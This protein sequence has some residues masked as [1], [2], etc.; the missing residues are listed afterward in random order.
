[1]K[2]GY[3]IVVILLCFASMPITAQTKKGM[4]YTLKYENQD[5]SYEILLNDVPVA[6][7]FGLSSGFSLKKELNQYILKS[8]KQEI[9]IRIYPQKKTETSFEATVSKTAK[10][11][12]SIKKNTEPLSLLDIANARDKGIQT[13]WDVVSFETPKIESDG[14]FYEF[15]TS[16]NVNDKDITWK[17]KGWI[18]SKDL[19]NETDLRKQVDAFYEN[20]KNIL[21]SKKQ[22]EYLKL[23]KTS[24][25]EEALSKPWFGVNFEKDLSNEILKY[26]NDERNFIYPCENAELKFYAN[27][28]IVTLIC[29][30]ITIFGYSPLISKTA[31]N[32]MPK[33]HTIYLHKPKNSDELEIIR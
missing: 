12:I 32:A 15:K 29:K 28:K 7:N 3:L 30:D 8:G 19:R 22:E 2:K 10:V 4:L 27:G 11:K 31:K 9:T 23:L 6:T 24:L 13:E 5:C 16:F 17:I 21:A 33:V 26:A 20:F 25:H 14:S 1:M 18:E